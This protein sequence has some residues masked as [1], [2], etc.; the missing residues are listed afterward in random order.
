MHRYDGYFSEQYIYADAPSATWGGTYTMAADGTRMFCCL[1]D[2]YDSYAIIS[3]VDM[4]KACWCHTF[5]VRPQ[6]TTT[7]TVDASL[8]GNSYDNHIAGY[9]FGGHALTLGDNVWC[10]NAIGGVAKHNK[11]TNSFTQNTFS[12]T[13]FDSNF[14]GPTKFNAVSGI[15]GLVN[16]SGGME[17]NSISSMLRVN[18]SG[19]LYS[20][21]FSDGM[22]S[23]NVSGDIS[24]TASGNMSYVTVAGYL[25]K[26][27]IVD[28]ISLSDIPG[29]VVSCTVT[30]DSNVT[31]DIN[32]LTILGNILGKTITVSNSSLTPTFAAVD[33]H[34]TLR[35]WN[36]ADLIS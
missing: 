36:P 2:S 20:G 35:I 19:Q 3:E 29:Y 9:F 32:N 8:I 11:I 34:G 30:T 1:S 7:E 5:G 25:Q 26:S 21:C 4:S 6:L 22:T 27:M 14:S 23:V 33:S 16:I 15:V 17:R 28:R 13:M 10:W 31:S 24:Y 18:I 12:G